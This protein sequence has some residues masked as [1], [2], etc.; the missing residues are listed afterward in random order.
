MKRKKRTGKRRPQRD[1]LAFDAAARARGM[2][3]G[4]AQVQETCSDYQHMR[5]VPKHY[6]KVGTCFRLGKH[7]RLENIRVFR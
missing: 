3:Y 2:T 6:H 5:Q 1:I 7:N 4:Q